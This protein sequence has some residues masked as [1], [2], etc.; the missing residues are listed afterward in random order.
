MELSR[1]EVDQR[2]EAKRRDIIGVTQDDRIAA[3]VVAER[4]RVIADNRVALAVAVAVVIDEAFTTSAAQGG[5]GGVG[6]QILDSVATL[7]EHDVTARGHHV[8]DVDRVPLGPVGTVIV[9]IDAVAIEVLEVLEGDKVDVVIMDPVDRVEVE[10][11]RSRNDRLLDVGPQTLGHQRQHGDVGRQDAAVALDV[12]DVDANVEGA[13]AVLAH[14]PLGIQRHRHR[15]REV[16]R[17]GIADHLTGHRGEHVPDVPLTSRADLE[18]R[19]QDVVALGDSVEVVEVGPDI[20]RRADRDLHRT[21]DVAVPVGHV[22]GQIAGPHLA[23][24]AIGV[25]ADVVDHREPDAARLAIDHLDLEDAGQIGILPVLELVLAISPEL[26]QDVLVGR[27]VV[28]RDR[29][30]VKVGREGPRGI[31]SQAAP[32][33][34]DQAT[35]VRG[36]ELELALDGRV[37]VLGREGVGPLVEDLYAALVRIHIVVHEVRRTDERRHIL[38]ATNAVL[39]R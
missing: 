11:Q 37:I 34:P 6:G 4:R 9:V 14:Q 15:L 28:Q 27:I 16:D 8:V 17:R 32:G 7:V 21:V 29:R 26:H 33:S 19:P 36:A 1:I 23:A 31:R 12:A 22:V 10:V 38:G 18:D 35:V 30:G 25:I 2:R 5:E 13:G 20:D 3:V 39:E 24:T